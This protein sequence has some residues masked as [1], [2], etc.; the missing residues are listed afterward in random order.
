MGSVGGVPGNPNCGPGEGSPYSGMDDFSIVDGIAEVTKKLAAPRSHVPREPHRRDGSMKRDSQIV[1][2]VRG[3]QVRGPM[4]VGS[5]THRFHRKALGS[6]QSAKVQTDA[7]SGDAPMLPSHSHRRRILSLGLGLLL[8]TFLLELVLRWLL[9]GGA[10]IGWSIRQPGRFADYQS[11]ED[12]YKLASRWRG[13][14]ADS[15]PNHYHPSLGWVS[16]ALD[17]ATLRHKHSAELSGQEL[18]LLYGDSYSQCVTPPGTRFE[19]HWP[20]SPFAG[21]SQLLNYGVSGYGLDQTALLVQATAGTVAQGSAVVLV[22]VFIDDDLDRCAL[23]LR[24]YPKPRFELVNGSLQL[25]GTPVPTLAAYLEEHPLSIRS[26]LG[27][28]I[29]RGALRSSPLGDRWGAPDRRDEKADL[30]RALT[31]QII[32]TLEEQSLRYG[33][34]L[35]EGEERTA[36]YAPVE[37]WRWATLVDVLESSEVAYLRPRDALRDSSKGNEAAVRRLFGQGGELA[38]HYTADGNA[39]VAAAM[40]SFVREL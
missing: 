38:D 6:Y 33:F 25:R 16:S 11:E 26:Y 18:V 13:D 34:V 20:R 12:Y 9:L 29:T 31:Q 3:G 40:A 30:A 39:I 2:E 17:A 37:D 15:A 19:D 24:G 35:F 21:D 32:D 4:A 8:C 23:G 5:V 27:R 22:G 14:G 28:L 7:I 36:S 10:D 1:R